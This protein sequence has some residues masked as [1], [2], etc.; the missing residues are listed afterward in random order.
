LWT[1]DVDNDAFVMDVR[2]YEL[3]DLAQDMPPTFEALSE[4]I[5]PADRDRVRVVATRVI[6]GP[7][8]IDFILTSTSD[9]R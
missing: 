2:A 5:H 4:K 1:G 3:W 8:E 6:V 7:Y 9:I